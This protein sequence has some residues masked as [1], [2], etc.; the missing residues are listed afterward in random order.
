MIENLPNC[1]ETKLAVT[2]KVDV[3]RLKTTSLRFKGYH[4]FLFCVFLLKSNVGFVIS[5]GEILVHLKKKGPTPL[6]KMIFIC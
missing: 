2:P 3:A 1:F 4:N 5:E 6:P